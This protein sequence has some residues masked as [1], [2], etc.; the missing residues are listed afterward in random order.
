MEPVETNTIQIVVNGQPKAVPAGLNI[1][2]LLDRLGID[3]QKVAVELNRAIVRK[4]DWQAAAVE[5]RASI[6][7]VWFVGGGAA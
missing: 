4:A 5:D 2:T 3:K 7:V 1:L 6:E